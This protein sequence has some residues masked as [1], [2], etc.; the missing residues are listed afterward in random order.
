VLLDEVAH[1]RQPE[2][3]PPVVARRRAVGL[4]EAIEDERQERRLDADPGVA[5]R[6]LDV[7]TD[8]RTDPARAQSHQPA[9][10][11]ELDRVRQ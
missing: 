5:H 3:E 2:P 4:T 8:R 7:P 10:G 1:D 6:H 9:V 11:R